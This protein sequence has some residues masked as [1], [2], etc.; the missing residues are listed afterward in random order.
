MVVDY[1]RCPLFVL[2][3]KVPTNLKDTDLKLMHVEV[4]VL[5]RNRMRPNEAL[6][7]L[8][9]GHKDNHWLQMLEQDGTMVRM[10][11]TLKDI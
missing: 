2:R 5:D 6:G 1:Q 8:R 10:M 3:F 11:H 9:I 7:K 4:T